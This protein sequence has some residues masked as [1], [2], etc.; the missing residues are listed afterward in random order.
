MEERRKFVRLDTTVRIRYK[1]LIPTEDHNDTN[2][3][4]LSSGG[5]KIEVKEPI[6]PSTV[7]WLEINLPSE[8][9]PL[10]AKGEVIWQEK[11]AAT[12]NNRYEMGIKFLEMDLND[13]NRL[14]KYLFS[15]L[16]SKF[17]QKSN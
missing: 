1:V 16:H 3:R 12:E 6:K 13:R 2:S 17:E 4:D 15:L 11:I 8:T 14:S 9:D 7:L 10:E 5:V